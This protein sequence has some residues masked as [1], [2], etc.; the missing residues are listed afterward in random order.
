M[1]VYLQKSN[2]RNVSKLSSWIWGWWKKDD[3]YIYIYIIDLSCSLTPLWQTCLPSSPAPQWPQFCFGESSDAHGRVTVTMAGQWIN[4]VMSNGFLVGGFNPLWRILVK[5]GIFPKKGWKIKI[6]IKPPPR[7]WF[8]F[9]WSIT[10][11]LN[12]PFPIWTCFISL[13]Y[14]TFSEYYQYVPLPSRQQ[15]HP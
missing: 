9:Q 8:T 3:W 7:F 6:K 13:A 10:L 11:P 1:G 4:A 12:F 14:N 2:K 15:H 5:M